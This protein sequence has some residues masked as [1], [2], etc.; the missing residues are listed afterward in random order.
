MMGSKFMAAACFLV[1]GAVQASILPPNQ[2]HLED[3]LIKGGITQAQFLKTIDMVSK[4]YAP[5]LKKFDGDLKIIGDWDDSTVNAFADRDG[6]NW[7]VYMF[8]GLARRVEV[9]VDGFALVICHELG[10]H[11]GGF[12]YVSDWAADEGQSDYFATQAC[13]R[14]IWMNDDAG[15]ARAAS[16]VHPVAKQKC[17]G[18]WQTVK[19]RNLCYRVA[20]A[21]LSLARLLGALEGVKPDFSKLDTSVVPETNHEHPAAQCRLDTYLAGGLCDVKFNDNMIP[22]VSTTMSDR[23]RE[24]EAL[25]VSCSQFDKTKPFAGRPKCWFK[26]FIR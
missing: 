14:K 12:P 6:S 2:L 5:I 8:G 11:V 17:D 16:T 18:R 1:C 21:G 26:Q 13:G 22:G 10:H 23:N 15:N 25:S 19:D 3:G 20:G 9:T 4:V 7:N 24:K